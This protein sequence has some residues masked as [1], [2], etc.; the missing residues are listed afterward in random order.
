MKLKFLKSGGFGGLNIGCEL[1]TEKL[2]RAEADE[3]FELVKRAGLEKAGTNRSARGRDLMNYEIILEHE[4]KKTR[5]FFDDM[6]VPENLQ[7]LL[8]FL[9]R[10]SKAMALDKL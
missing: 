1:D 10:R 5:A 6:M 7:D 9:S 4:G 8:E 2:P 3:L